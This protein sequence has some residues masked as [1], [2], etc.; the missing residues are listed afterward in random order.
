MQTV[1]VL[2]IS[3]AH[4]KALLIELDGPSFAIVGR[5][6]FEIPWLISK[7][8]EE[9]IIPEVAA[10]SFFDLTGI[11]RDSGIEE[12]TDAIVLVSLDT[13]TSLHLKLPFGDPRRLNRILSLEVQDLVPFEI[14]DFVLSH[15]AVRAS[16]EGQYDIHVSLLS[17]EYLAQI[18]KSLKEHAID[19]AIV[20]TLPSIIGASFE[21]TDETF[22]PNTCFVYLYESTCC[23]LT[24]I[25]N[26]L[27]CDNIIPIPSTLENSDVYIDYMA[28]H[29]DLALSSIEKK[30]QVTGIE[31]ILLGSFLPVSSLETRLGREI[32]RRALLPVDNAISDEERLLAISALFVRDGN[33][34]LLLSNFRIGEFAYG[35]QLKEVLNGFRALAPYIISFIIALI[36]C[37]TGFY[38][39]RASRIA[40]LENLIRE[41]IMAEVPEMRPDEINPISFLQNQLYQ[42]DRQLKELGSASQYSPLAALTEISKDF[43]K[44]DNITIKRMTIK[45][46]KIEIEGS[47][48]DYAS[49]EK[50]KKSLTEKKSIYCKVKQLS[51]SGAGFSTSGQKEFNFEVWLCET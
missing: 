34:P 5:A 30:F 4:S 14:S 50:I 12:W 26:E 20:T 22:A 37:L 3:K 13:Y 10:T 8:A 40:T 39:I 32:K 24:Q 25:N 23:I 51:K 44:S 33:S 6:S 18:L 35:L 27:V 17:R 21:N 2:D 11:L 19:P 45:G 48:P 29:I 41:K 16:E 1:L 36:C 9:E 15:R 46:N 7:P 28:T 42:M 49:G 31:V 47:A 38:G 43:P